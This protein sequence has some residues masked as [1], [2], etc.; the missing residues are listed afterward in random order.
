VNSLD[1]YLLERAAEHLALNEPIAAE[2]AANL[3]VRLRWI[4]RRIAAVAANAGWVNDE[5][6]SAAGW[7]PYPL[8]RVMELC[9]KVRHRTANGDASVAGAADCE[10]ACRA[11]DAQIHEVLAALAAR[12]AAEGGAR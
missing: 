2:D 11:I 9:G 4:D 10:A 12:R 3:F 5:P 6:P 7:L 8:G 1:T